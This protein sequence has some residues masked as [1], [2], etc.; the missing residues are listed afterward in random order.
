MP[1]TYLVAMIIYEPNLSGDQVAAASA[2]SLCRQRLKA[3]INMEAS[4]SHA[5]IV[6]DRE[7]ETERE[8]EGK[9]VESCARCAF[10]G[11]LKAVKF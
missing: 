4:T 1:K 10:V 6:R 2:A 11:P 3:A 5:E 7:G 9:S 8:W